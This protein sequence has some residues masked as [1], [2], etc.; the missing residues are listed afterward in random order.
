MRTFEM[1]QLMAD[2]YKLVCSVNVEWYECIQMLDHIEDKW[3]NVD[4]NVKF[5]LPR[6]RFR[7][8]QA[9]IKNRP[10]FLGEYLY[11]SGEQC[12]FVGFDEHGC[13]VLDFGKHRSHTDGKYLDWD[14]PKPKTVMVELPYEFVRDKVDN[15]YDTQ[16]ARACIK[17]FKELK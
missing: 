4:A 8:A 16:L 17:A 1:H 10:L 5:H 3:C 15:G 9:V 7:V 12:Q 13:F 2:S 14:K 6:N 11:C